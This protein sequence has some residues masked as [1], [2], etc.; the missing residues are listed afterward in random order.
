VTHPFHPL[1]GQTFVLVVCRQNWGEER[2]Y[3]QDESGALCSLPRAW[4]SLAPIDPFVHLAAERSAFRVAD[5][6]ELSRLLTFLS[7]EQS[8][9]DMQEERGDIQHS[10]T[11]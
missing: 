7:R 11:M 1:R 3:Y 6:L 10:A 5:L 8:Q 2:V 4:T 9:P